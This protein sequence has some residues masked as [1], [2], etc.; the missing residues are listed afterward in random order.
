MTNYIVFKD[1]EVVMLVKEREPWTNY[2][3][4]KDGEVV[5]VV[6]DKRGP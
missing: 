2:I 3:V 6:I 5:K 4:L 1:G